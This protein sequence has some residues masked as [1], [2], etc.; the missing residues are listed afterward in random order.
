VTLRPA[1]RERAAASQQQQPVKSREERRSK[2]ERVLREE[3]KV[4]AL[5]RCE[6]PTW[7]R[8]GEGDGRGAESAWGCCSCKTGRPERCFVTNFV[9]CLF[10][11]VAFG[12]LR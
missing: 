3:G 8:A 5:A 9:F 4:P 2:A 7:S 1:G 6:R 10:Y 11:A 12:A